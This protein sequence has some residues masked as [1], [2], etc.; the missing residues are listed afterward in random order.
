MKDNIAMAHGAG[1][2]LMDKLIK[3]NILKYL[4]SKKSS[5]DVP[6]S[7]LDDAG[8]IEDIVFTTDS[9]V[10]KP[11]FF[12]GG[13]IGSLS[14]SGT[15]ND[16]S[17]IGAKPVAISTAFIIEE[18]FSIEKLEEIVKSIADTAEQADVAVLTGDTKVMEKGS[19][20]EFVINTSGIGKRSP[21]LDK[22][23][24]EVKRYREFNSRWL[25]DSN[26]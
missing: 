7:A 22:N 18:G 15:V 8:V 9:Y 21:L 2:E 6:L 1:G 4:E 14:I 25:L 17:V 3:N 16:L 23:I 26:L 12:P 11:L 20:D 19:I 5:F 10:I 13:N 24:E